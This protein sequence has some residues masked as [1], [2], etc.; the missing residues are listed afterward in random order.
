MKMGDYKSYECP[1]CKADAAR[2]FEGFGFNFKA[3]A[4]APIGN[5]GVTKHDYPTADYVVGRDAEQRW[6]EYA[7][8][9]KVKDKVREA[10]GTHALV[11]TGTKDYLDYHVGGESTLVKRRK[12]IRDLRALK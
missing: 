1:S 11:R 10:G 9:Q 12:L 5:T 3:P 4:K 8:R 2:V 6:A 7:E